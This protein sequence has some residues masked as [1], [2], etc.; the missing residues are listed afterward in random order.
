MRR[1]SYNG[2]K[3]LHDRWIMNGL[4][5]GKNMCGLPMVL[6]DMKEVMGIQDKRKG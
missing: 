3:K 2:F 4:I 6:L 5:S 1:R